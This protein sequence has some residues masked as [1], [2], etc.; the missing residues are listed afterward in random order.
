MVLKNCLTS[1]MH[2]WTSTYKPSSTAHRPL[3]GYKLISGGAKFSIRL[4][5]HEGHTYLTVENFPYQLAA[6]GSDSYLSMT[7]R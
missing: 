5:D 6:S 4:R 3:R 2:I 7:K 1:H